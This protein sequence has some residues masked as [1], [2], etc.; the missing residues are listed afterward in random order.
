MRSG[1]IKI[2]II[3][4]V[5]SIIIY[6]IKN[7]QNFKQ[8]IEKALNKNEIKKIVYIIG[9]VTNFVVIVFFMKNIYQ[10]ITIYN[11]NDAFQEV[12]D[13][14]DKKMQNENIFYRN[15]I[16]NKYE[17]QNYDKPYIPNGFSYVEGEWNT[18]YVIQDENQNQY[19]WVPCT[20]KNIENIQTLKRSNFVS[21]A[22]IPYNTCYNNEYEEFLK[23]ALENGGFYISRYEIGKEND[24]PVSKKDVDVWRKVTIDD[25][26]NIINTMYEDETI[27]CK[28]INGYAYDTT[29]EWIKSNNEL[30]NNSVELNMGFDFEPEI[31]LKTG[32]Y[33]Y[34][35]IYDF[36]DNILELTD[37][38][39]YDTIIIRG[40]SN[41]KETEY[42]GALFSE[43]NRYSILKNEITYGYVDTIG[44][45]S[46][47]YNK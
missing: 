19:V 11:K 15:A 23:S 28:L 41:S 38:V 46:V 40:F 14:S 32:R 8:S 7:F 35:N 16:N 3:I 29:L 17:N 34:N 10:N 22:F 42:A 24:K 13:E 45:R 30:S 6:F 25:A 26:K 33:Q 37:E 5:V 21:K 2:G 27:D 36:C 1:C 4:F 31:M 9:F 47:L 44:F 18:G 43:H 20:N 12:F 39:S